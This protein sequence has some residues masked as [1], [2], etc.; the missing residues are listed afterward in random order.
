METTIDSSGTNGP[1]GSKDYKDAEAFTS[2]SASKLLVVVHQDDQ[3][4]GTR[5]WNLQTQQPLKDFFTGGENGRVRVR[6]PL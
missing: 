1:F 6:S 4:V 5:A 3:F 2:L